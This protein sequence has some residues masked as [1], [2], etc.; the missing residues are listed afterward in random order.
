MASRM[1]TALD[2]SILIVL[3]LF[4]H[5]S[6]AAKN[7]DFRVLKV[8]KNITTKRACIDLCNKTATDKEKCNLALF[9]KALKTCYLLKCPKLPTCKGLNLEELKLHPDVVKN[10]ER[11][12]EGPNTLPRKITKQA[13]AA[14]SQTTLIIISTTNKTSSPIT[15]TTVTTTAATTTTTTATTIVPST[16]SATVTIAPSTTNV[17]F[18]LIISTTAENKNLSSSSPGTSLLELNTKRVTNKATTQTTVLTTSSTA[19]SISTTTIKSTTLKPAAEAASKILPA[20]P[21]RTPS[22]PTVISA[23]PSETS[24]GSM[25]VPPEIMT[26]TTL[27]SSS[28][29]V[30]IV[31]SLPPTDSDERLSTGSHT[32]L[33][34]TKKATSPPT[35]KPIKVPLPTSSI[36]KGLTTT[37]K[38]TTWSALS[39]PTV[40]LKPTTKPATTSA[41]PTAGAKTNATPANKAISGTTAKPK[42]A[43]PG[44]EENWDDNVLIATG[45]IG[46]HLVDTSSLLAVLLFGVLFS[47]ATI[48]VFITLACESYKKKDYTQVDYLI[49]GMYVDSGV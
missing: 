17:L 33:P 7:K 18:S 39:R 49:N 23:V 10:E 44:A 1:W 40:T 9:D 26:S 42:A 45:P 38:R 24:N 4:T 16:T 13:R 30:S 2:F 27:L 12:T 41:P 29:N 36:G 35:I 21:S 47:M 31:V 6:H 19:P 37:A 48:I 5:S 43:L 46:K 3:C 34:P 8:M 22:V 28:A 11:K 25:A 15:S 14:P 32:S 20:G